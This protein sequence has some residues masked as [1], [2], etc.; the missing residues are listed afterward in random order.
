MYLVF[1]I[2]NIS[3][4]R[5]NQLNNDNKSA[6]I[7]FTGSSRLLAAIYKSVSSAKRFNF[8]YVSAFSMSLIYRI[9]NKGPKTDPWGT[10]KETFIIVSLNL[11]SKFQWILIL[12]QWILLLDL[13]SGSSFHPAFSLFCFCLAPS[14][15]KWLFYDFGKF[16][17]IKNVNY[18]LFMRYKT[19]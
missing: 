18:K 19:K 11:Q 9:N 8:A 16:L 4:L 5:F 3:L 2:F 6:I 12:E 10:P 17:S 13:Y 14:I 1:S 15:L 7:L